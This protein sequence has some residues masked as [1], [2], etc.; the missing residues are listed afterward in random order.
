[1][2]VEIVLV[3]HGQSEGN[4]DRI[5]TGHG[6]SH[7][8]AHGRLQAEATARHLATTAVQAIY[9]SDLARALETAAP[10]SA[11]TG[12]P[13]LTSTDLRERDVGAFTGLSFADVQAR[14]PEGW[15]A[16]MSRD[17]GY[18]PPGGES[19]A[20]CGA[21]VGRFLDDLL[22]R[23]AAG[24]LVVYSHGVAI[25]HML[26]HLVGLPVEAAPRAFFHVDNCSLQRFEHH[27]ERGSLRI[28]SVNETWH[29][30]PLAD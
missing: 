19:H 15:Q 22:G 12:L 21:R 29:L 18:R 6:P 23:H 8:T 2:S 3:R 26:R 20:D 28:L 10:L 11:L 13:P 4:R 16:L 9:S 17:P 14:F 5:F 30:P 24:R 27:P 1:M 25:N 7:L